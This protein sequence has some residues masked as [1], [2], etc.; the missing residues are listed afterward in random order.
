MYEIYVRQ[1]WARANDLTGS[2]SCPDMLVSLYRG[3]IKVL[4]SWTATFTDGT[5]IVSGRDKNQVAGLELKETM[6]LCRRAAQTMHI[7]NILCSMYYAL[8]LLLYTMLYILYNKYC[9]IL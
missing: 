1:E 2:S 9:I 8:H 3:W 7:K 5:A 6:I 4:T